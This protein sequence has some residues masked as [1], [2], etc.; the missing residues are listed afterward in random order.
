M[1]GALTAELPSQFCGG[2]IDFNTQPQQ[3]AVSIP[4]TPPEPLPMPAGI[5]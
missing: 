5:A 2:I 3:L 4:V 1:N